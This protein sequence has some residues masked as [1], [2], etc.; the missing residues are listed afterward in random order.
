MTIRT[1]LEKLA[2]I[3]ATE[4]QGENV[5]LDARIEALKVLTPYFS[6][7][8]KAAKGDAP[9]PPNGSTFAGMKSMIA[10]AE[11]A[12]PEVEDE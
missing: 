10:A 11:A 3:I 5:K 8:S 12:E 6:A 7:Q 2:M 1:E 4:A 9:P